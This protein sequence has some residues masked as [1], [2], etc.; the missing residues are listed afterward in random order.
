MGG[1]V[2]FCQG[3]LTDQEDSARRSKE[4]EYLDLALPSSHLLQSSSMAK[5]N[6]EAKARERFWFFWST[7]RAQGRVQEQGTGST[8]A[9]RRQMTQAIIKTMLLISRQ[10]Q[11]KQKRKSR[12]MTMYTWKCGRGKGPSQIPEKMTLQ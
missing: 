5:V 8:G 12:N 7:S 4:N 1:L 11:R 3:T 6:H 9:G 2:N 10:N